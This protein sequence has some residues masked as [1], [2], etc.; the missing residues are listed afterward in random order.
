M[1]DRVRVQFPVPDIILVYVTSKSGTQ[2]ETQ[3]AESWGWILGEG[4]LAG[5]SPPARESRGA[6]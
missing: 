4:Q 2:P 3:R 5:P 1:G 6:L